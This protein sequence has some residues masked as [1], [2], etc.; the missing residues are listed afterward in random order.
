MMTIAGATPGHPANPPGASSTLL[1][2]IG[3]LRARLA[4]TK[5]EIRAAQRLRHAV[6][7]AEFTAPGDETGIDA[8]GYDALCDHLIVLDTAIEG[9]D[10]DRIIG[11]Y[12]LLPQKKLAGKPFYSD[13]TFDISALLKRHDGRNFLELGRSC[14][15]PDYRSKRTIELLW[16]GIWAYCRRNDIDVMFG[17]ASFAGRVPAQHA[18]ALSFLHHH[19]RAGG[20]WAVSARPGARIDMDFMPP[21]AIDLK[22]AMRALPPL[23]KGYLRLGATFGDGAVIDHAFASVDVLVVLPVEQISARYVSYY[24]A[25]ADRFAA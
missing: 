8:D 23:I 20:D 16:Q 18:M 10:T 21:E 25:D 24:G 12:R 3:T 22:A 1:G 11:T 2:E 13:G 17:C 4:A 5:A 7:S 15:L 14:V 9:T 19:A 6:F